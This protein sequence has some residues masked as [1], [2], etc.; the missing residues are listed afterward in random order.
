M[1][2]GFGYD[3]H[4]LAA[5][6]K[7]ILGGVEFPFE[8]GLDGHS[9]ADVLLHAVCDA[10]LGAMGEGDIGKHFPNT[11][12][13]YRNISSLKLLARVAALMREKGLTIGNVDATV[14]AARPTIGPHF[15]RMT[16]KI[17]SAL[18]VPGRRINLKATT[19]EGLGFVGEGKG[20]AAYAA[21]LLEE[22][23]DEK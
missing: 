3:V 14:V 7:L 21:V 13:R 1:L 16:E 23:R 18:E 11:D 5:G 10:I 20:M 6:R 4:P 2:I 22:A 9:D 8:K 19:S 15:P 17:A 12:P